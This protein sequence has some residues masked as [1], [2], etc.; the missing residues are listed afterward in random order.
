[1]SSSAFSRTFIWSLLASV[2]VVGAGLAGMRWLVA[3]V[4]NQQSWLFI[5]GVVTV[6]ACLVFSGVMLGVPRI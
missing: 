2:G 3:G 4:S 1:M 5:L 6:V